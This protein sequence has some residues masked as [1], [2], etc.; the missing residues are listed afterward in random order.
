M[1]SENVF[2]ELKGRFPQLQHSDLTTVNNMTKF[3]L[4]CCV[5]HNICIDYGDSLDSLV[6]DMRQSSQGTHDQKP[7][8]AAVEHLEKRAPY[9]HLQK[10]NEK[11]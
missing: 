11:Q 5:L 7:T 6:Q 4:A 10:L 9:G 8:A 2:G 3:I 1:L